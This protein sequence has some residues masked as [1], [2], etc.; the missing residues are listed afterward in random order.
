MTELEKVYIACHSKEVASIWQT[1]LQGKGFKVVSSWHNKEFLP[2]VEHTVEERFE[3]AQEDLHEIEECD[4]LLLVSGAGKYS[5]GKF[6]EAGIAYGL[7]KE[8]FYVGERE[9][10]LCYL[11]DKMDLGEENG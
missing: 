9:N 11:F 4:T 10:M 8:V 2:T 6:I 3:I 5:G 7:G 1:V